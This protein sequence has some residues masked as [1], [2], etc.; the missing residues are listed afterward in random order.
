M[1]RFRPV[2]RSHQAGVRTLFS[3][4]SWVC[5]GVKAGRLLPCTSLRSAGQSPKYVGSRKKP[6][7]YACKGGGGKGRGGGGGGLISLEEERNAAERGGH[8]QACRHM[9]AGTAA[10]A[11]R[12][13]VWHPHGMPHP[14]THLLPLRCAP[15]FCVVCKGLRPADG[16]GHRNFSTRH[17]APALTSG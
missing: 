14:P 6:P 10:A 4:S 13:G 15:V 3:S 12:D 7:L 1:W 17:E 8:M 5:S 11:G 9:P 2:S 16:G